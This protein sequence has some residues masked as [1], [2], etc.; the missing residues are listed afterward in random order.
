MPSDT[1]IHG[2]SEAMTGELAATLLDF[3]SID[4]SGEP[5]LRPD[6]K[7]TRKARPRLRPS[8]MMIALVVIIGVG[9][10]LLVSLLTARP[11]SESPV[12][13]ASRSG[14]IT[15]RTE[16]C[17]P[18]TPGSKDCSPRALSGVEVVL[19]D[20]KSGASAWATTNADGS[21]DC[22]VPPGAYTVSGMTIAGR[23][24][25]KDPISGVVQVEELGRASYVL[26]Y[27]RR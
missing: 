4:L 3:D 26:I 22:V 27:E 15:I 9:V 24:D 20:V 2:Q 17:E 13:T 10:A 5:D 16:S 18:T 25:L 12:L 14:T 7:S 21:T 19:I 11:S 23:S 1:P 8:P 6:R